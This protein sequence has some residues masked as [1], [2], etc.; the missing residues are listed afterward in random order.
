MPKT[1][2]SD[3]CQ[4]EDFTPELPASFPQQLVQA[5]SPAL[6]RGKRLRVSTAKALDQSP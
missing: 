6:G 4:A 3:P 5:P 1:G 2:A